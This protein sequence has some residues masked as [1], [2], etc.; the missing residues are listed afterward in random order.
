MA[1]YNSFEELGIYQLAREQNVPSYIIF[2]DSTLL[3]LATYL[4][5]AIDDLNKISG[6]GAFKIEQYG[7]LFISQIQEYCREAKLKSRITLKQ[8]IRERKPKKMNLSET[9]SL[10][11]QM[12]NKGMSVAEII[13]ERK[14]SRLTIE[15]HLCFFISTGELNVTQFVEIR[16]QR[17]ITKAV[18]TFGALSLK[19]L[20]ENLEEDIAYSDIKMV[21]AGL[22]ED[23]L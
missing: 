5:L 19:V 16:K 18:E 21:L 12:Y 22:K 17:A 6:F 2:S 11:L 20:K 15:E 8:P 10:T 14:L 23:Q 9:K 4:P 1:N 7:Q 3:D 13:N